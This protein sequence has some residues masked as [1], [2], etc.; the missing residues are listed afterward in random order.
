[1]LNQSHTNNVYKHDYSKL[2]ISDFV[3]TTMESSGKIF[4]STLNYNPRFGNC[5]IPVF[6]VGVSQQMHTVTNI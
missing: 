1:M 3:S 4:L 5:Q 6:S 2:L